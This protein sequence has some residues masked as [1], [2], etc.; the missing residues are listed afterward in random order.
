V[1][2]Y[3]ETKAKASDLYDEKSAEAKAAA[4]EAADKASKAYDEKLA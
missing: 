4:S 1:A 2:K 3:D